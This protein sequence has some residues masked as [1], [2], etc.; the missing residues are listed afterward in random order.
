MQADIEDKFG[1][2]PKSE[3]V[4]FKLLKEKKHPE[5][6]VWE[7]QISELESSFASMTPESLLDF[8]SSI[9]PIIEFWKSKEGTYNA[10][11]KNE[12]QLLYASRLNLGLAYYYLE[13]FDEAIKY[14]QLVEN[15]SHKDKDGRKLR[16]KIE[17]LQKEMSEKGITS[18]HFT[19]EMDA[20]NIA[21]IQEAVADKEAAIE[22]GD[23]T[24]MD[25]FKSKMNVRPDSEVRKGAVY[26]RSGRKTEGVF[27]YT[28]IGTAPDFF[29][30]RKVAFG[31]LLDDELKR[32][33]L[34]LSDLD[35]FYMEDT[36]FE[37]RELKYKVGPLKQK[38]KNAVVTPIQDFEKTELLIAYKGNKDMPITQYI[39]I[40]KKDGIF[41]NPEGMLFGGF[42]KVMGKKLK[43]C[44]ELAEKIKNTDYEDKHLEALPQILLEYDTCDN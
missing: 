9:Q 32:A 16:E 5:Y 22:D 27:V 35:S 11:D 24:Q 44:K 18:R 36:K 42:S 26:S 12:K 14:A 15:G 10:N 13:N 19:I 28:P 37:V 6:G 20:D 3:K 21:D 43:D 1:L 34:K 2:T 17:K 4:E 30:Q 25:G 23:L 29:N 38:V 8:E 39:I 33:T 41:F 40:M 31:Y 7:A